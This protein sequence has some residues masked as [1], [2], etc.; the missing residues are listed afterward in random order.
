[1]SLKKNPLNGNMAN[2]KPKKRPMRSKRSGVKKSQL[3]KNNHETIYNI[4]TILNSQ[5]VLKTF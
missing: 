5:Q 4:W 3:I 2:A 1:M